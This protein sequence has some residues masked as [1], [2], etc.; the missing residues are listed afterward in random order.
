MASREFE[1]ELEKR[2]IE[3]TAEL[4]KTVESLNR[5]I[6]ERK[7][8]DGELKDTRARLQHVLAVTPSIIYTNQASGDYACTFVS[9]SLKAIMGYTPHEMLDDPDFWTTH[10]HPQDARHVLPDVFRL[11]AEGGGTVEYRFRHADGHYRWFQD[12]FKV[13]DDE[14]GTP[15]EIVGSW[16]DITQ[17]KLAESFNVLYQASLKIQEPLGLKKWG[18]EFLRKG[19]EVLHLDR[20]SILLADTDGQWLRAVA[21]T[22]T[23][24]PLTAIRV[25]IGPEGGGLAQAY[26]TRQSVVWDGQGPEPDGLRPKPPYDQIEAFRSRAF[27]IMPLVL[28]RGQAIGVLEAGW[29]YSRRPFDRATLEPLQLLATQA[30]L[31]LEH[32]RLYAAAQPVLRRSLQLKEV[33][34]AFAEAVKALL[35]YDRIGVV[36]P[37]GERLVMALSIAEPPLAS[38]QGESWPQTAGTAVDWVLTNRRPRLIR[39]LLTEQTFTDD[40]FM[41]QEGVRATLMLPLLAGDKPVG[42]FFLDSRTSGAYTERDLELV[43]PVAQQLALAIENAQLFREI[44][45]KRRQVEIANQHKSAFLANVSHELRTPL[46]AVIG[47][48]E[49]LAARYFGEL[50]GKQAEYVNDI[51]TSGKHLLALIND[52]LDLSKIEAGRM[53]LDA[54]VFDLCA[55]LDNAAKLVRERAQRGGIEL[56]V[57]T[58]AALSTFRGDERKLRQ[59]VLNLLSNA[60]KFTPP[61]GSV[62]V[63]AE[64]VDGTTKIAVSDTGAGIAPEDQEA[65]FEAFR[66]VGSDVTRKREGTGLGLALAR[67]FVELHGGTIGVQSAPGKGSTFT[68]TLPIRHGG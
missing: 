55:A 44:E 43:D 51:R 21:S 9:E 66:Q 17:R 53:E 64:V 49:M 58:D 52:I 59:V 56:Q 62:R 61:G 1:Q 26:L 11:L 25:P 10:L 68:V 54:G 29:K 22:E 63:T 18:D 60:V 33:Y 14:T 38:W 42:V 28:Q 57:Q 36:V 7:G 12:T 41:I 6:A 24:E 3:R 5:Q 27:A 4:I 48:S 16:A 8:V 45:E 31:A 67:R 35:A 39:D 15:V 65:I 13:I 47:C 20:L 37:D 30:T 40:A 46:N 32:A 2:V 19:Q 50:T 23:A 34:P